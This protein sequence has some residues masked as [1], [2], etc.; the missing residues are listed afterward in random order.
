M[1][2][3]FGAPN[4][5]HRGSQD[6]FEVV[7]GNVHPRARARAGRKCRIRKCITILTVY[8]HNKL[9]DVHRRRALLNEQV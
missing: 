3:L 1:R 8:N 6:K 4:K 5:V 9:C 2:E 7:T